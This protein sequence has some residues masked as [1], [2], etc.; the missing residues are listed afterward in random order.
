M[1]DLPAGMWPRSKASRPSSL[2]SPSGD[3]STVFMLIPSAQPGSST[4]RAFRRSRLAVMWK[5]ASKKSPPR[6][7]VG[8]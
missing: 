5:R 7:A 3:G 2:A 6:I 1:Y 8:A 4:R